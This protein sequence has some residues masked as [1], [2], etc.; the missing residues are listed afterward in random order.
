MEDPKKKKIKKKKGNKNLFQ[1]A[2][3]FVPGNGRLLKKLLFDVEGE[4]GTD[5]R[6]KI[7][8]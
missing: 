3:Q 4:V 7:K 8:V 6:R 5:N 2:M 1:K